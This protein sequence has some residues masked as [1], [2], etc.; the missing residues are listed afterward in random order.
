MLECTLVMT[1][2]IQ[3]DLTYLTR[4]GM[5]L[6][7]LRVYRQLSQEELVLQG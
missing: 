3:K 5:R 4:F 2:D 1:L 6:R 7:W